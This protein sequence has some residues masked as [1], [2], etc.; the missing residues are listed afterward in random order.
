M[1]LL[2]R[3]TSIDEHLQPF[4][5]WEARQMAIH[6]FVHYAHPRVKSPFFFIRFNY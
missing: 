4:S 1:R 5:L 6:N 2:F 3:G